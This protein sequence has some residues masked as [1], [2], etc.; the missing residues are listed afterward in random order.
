MKKRP[1][2]ER[3]MEK[4]D[5]SG[6]DGCW[7]WS[8]KISYNGYGQFW[9]NG[10]DALAHRMAY[11]LFVGPIP[12]GLQ[13]DHLCRNRACVNPDHLEA[14]SARENLLRGSSPRLQN[15][16]S[17]SCM[18][19]HPRTSDNLTF[20]NGRKRCRVCGR[21]RQREYRSRRRIAGS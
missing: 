16:W 17:D 7:V 10:K 1:V 18:A 19:G 9:F 13:I 3:F 12:E 21:E 8:A 5:K 11:E 4:V 15:Y 14:V 6:S 2:V 20:V